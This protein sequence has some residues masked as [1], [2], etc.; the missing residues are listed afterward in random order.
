MEAVQRAQKAAEVGRY[1]TAARRFNREK[2]RDVVF[3]S[4]GLTIMSVME[5]AVVAQWKHA[6][7][8][9]GKPFSRRR[10]ARDWQ[11]VKVA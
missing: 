4:P 10:G 8:K 1:V 9:R 6:E 11:V 5:H 2:A 3:L 7:K